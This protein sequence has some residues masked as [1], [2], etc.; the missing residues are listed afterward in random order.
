MDGA[1]A[2]MSATVHR[3]LSQHSF[4]RKVAVVLE[5]LGLTYETIYLSF[6][7]GE[8]KAPEYTKYNPN[9]RIPTLIDHQAGDFVLWLVLH[10]SL[11]DHRFNIH[12]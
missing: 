2:T 9:G 5:E 7:K 10:I 6:D 8:Q 3:H 11:A 12:G 4:T 1:S